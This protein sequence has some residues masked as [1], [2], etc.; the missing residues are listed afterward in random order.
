MFLF[1]KKGPDGAPGAP[2]KPE[3]PLVDWKNSDQPRDSRE[4]RERRHGLK[5]NNYKSE[6]YRED[7][8]Y[9]GSDED[10]DSDYGYK[11]S[12]RIDRYGES[13]R[14]LNARRHKRTPRKSAAKPARAHEKSEPE[15]PE[16]LKKIIEAEAKNR[17]ATY[18]KNQFANSVFFN[19][20][21]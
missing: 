19:M 10:N 9:S 11:R 6:E 14:M 2:G 12:K 21:A 3:I 5:K 17:K 15:K 7:G 8:N 18:K 20:V 13:A 4:S 16:I 1:L